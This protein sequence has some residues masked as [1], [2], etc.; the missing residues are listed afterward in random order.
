[1]T[2][3][4]KNFYLDCGI[5]EIRRAHNEN[6]NERVGEYAFPASIFSLK[7]DSPV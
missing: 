3:G 6:S 5:N 4:D 7:L 2:H 1:M